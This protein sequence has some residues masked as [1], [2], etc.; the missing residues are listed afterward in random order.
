MRQYPSVGDFTLICYPAVLIILLNN[1]RF[2]FILSSVLSLVLWLAGG[3]RMR[4]ELYFVRGIVR[5][6]IVLVD[7]ADRSEDYW[8]IGS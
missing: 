6:L 1:L 7:L 4:E 8:C 2:L 5:F 3:Q